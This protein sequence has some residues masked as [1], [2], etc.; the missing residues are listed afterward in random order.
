VGPASRDSVDAAAPAEWDSIDFPHLQEQL[1]AQRDRPPRIAVP[2]WDDVRKGLPPGSPA[3][4]PLRIRW[5]L[6]CLGYQPEL[7]LGWS[8]CM[9]TFGQEANQDRI[10]EES[11][12]WVVTRTLHC[13]Y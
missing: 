1:Q 11:L 5:S 8:A 3:G 9:R 2:S 6:V 7:A 10:F 13:F 4:K 12:F